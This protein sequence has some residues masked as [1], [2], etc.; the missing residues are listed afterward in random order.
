MQMDFL[1]REKLQLG[2]YG[3]FIGHWSNLI[4]GALELDVFCCPECGKV[5]LF[6]PT[7]TKD[8]SQ[9]YTDSE[10][11]QKECPNCGG[12]HDFDFPQCPYCNFP[13]KA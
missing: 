1:G 8:K 2:E 13:Y 12:I 9:Q 7:L 5:E 11:P 3:A 6:R 4:S 10:L